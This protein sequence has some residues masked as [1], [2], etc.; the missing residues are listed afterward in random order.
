M[1]IASATAPHHF[2]SHLH[3][4]LFCTV[5]RATKY[6]KATPQKGIEHGLS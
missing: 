5:L 1:N 4:P 2:I 6:Q 3:S